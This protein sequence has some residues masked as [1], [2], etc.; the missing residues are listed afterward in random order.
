MIELNICYFPFAVK[1]LKFVSFGADVL[2]CFK[3]D[4]YFCLKA[5]HS[6]TNFAP[7]AIPQIQFSNN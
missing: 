1:F 6:R 5:G 3:F 2:F 7:S 4:I